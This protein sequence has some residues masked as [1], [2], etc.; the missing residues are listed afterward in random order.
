MYVA[1]TRVNMVSSPS[2]LAEQVP[3]MTAEQVE[4]NPWWMQFFAA[5]DRIGWWLEQ[6]DPPGE[7]VE[8]LAARILTFARSI[9]DPGPLQRRHRGRGHPLTAPASGAAARHRQ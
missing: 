6:E 9:A 1:G 8:Q 2:A 3:G 5:P 4:A 7:N